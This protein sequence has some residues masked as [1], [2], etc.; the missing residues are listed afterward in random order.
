MDKQ[1]LET[2]YQDYLSAL[3][4]YDLNALSLCYQLPCTLTLPE[5]IL[6][7]ENKKDFFQEF[8]AIFEQL[9]VACLKEIQVL[10]AS[11]SEINKNLVLVSIDWA[12]I[13]KNDDVFADFCAFFHLAFVN[14]QYKIVSVSSHELA[15]AKTLTHLLNFT[16]DRE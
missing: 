8:T 16:C 4:L 5:K 1:R 3:S 9:K 12:F 6:V 11:F 10:N 15:S 13:D 14:A 7:L 2:F